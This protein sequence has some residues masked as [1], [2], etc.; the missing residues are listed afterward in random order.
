M[1]LFFFNHIYID[2]LIYLSLFN[3][4]FKNIK[5]ILQFLKINKVKLGVDFLLTLLFILILVITKIKIN[6]SVN[7]KST[8][9]LT[10]FIFK[11]CKIYLIFL[12]K[13]LNKLK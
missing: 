1:F 12:K 7:K 13:I 2:I 4:F 3:I 8:P 6:K 9:N 5:Y 10:L 11:N